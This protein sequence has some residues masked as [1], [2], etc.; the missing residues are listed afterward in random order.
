MIDFTRRRF[1]F[2]LAAVPLMVPAVKHFV[3]PR[4][5]QTPLDQIDGFPLGAAGLAK[6]MGIDLGHDFA[7]DATPSSLRTGRR[8]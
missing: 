2:G 1:L 6:A 5:K 3:M 4:W 7:M 8:L